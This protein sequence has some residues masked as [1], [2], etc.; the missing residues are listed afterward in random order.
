[1]ENETKYGIK[2][3]NKRVNYID[4]ARGI[5]IILMVIGH[6]IQKGWKRNVIFSFHMPFFIIVSGMFHKDKSLKDTIKNIFSKLILPYISC[7][8][9]VNIISSII[10][11]WTIETTI[12]SWIKQICFSYSYWGNINFYRSAIPLGGIMVFSSI[13]NY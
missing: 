11:G 5:A 8:L 7:T 10:N 2:S 4:I 1:M 3:T 9:I 13:S 12:I 6:V